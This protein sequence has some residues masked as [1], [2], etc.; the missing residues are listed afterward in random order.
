MAATILAMHI[1]MG[2]E[3]LTDEILWHCIS[4]IVDGSG[5]NR[6]NPYVVVARAQHDVLVGVSKTLPTAHCF[7]AST[8]GGVLWY[9]NMGS[10]SEAELLFGHLYQIGKVSAWL[11]GSNP[12]LSEPGEIRLLGFTMP[13][14]ADLRVKLDVWS[15]ET[16]KIRLHA[17]QHLIVY[18]EQIRKQI[19]EHE[20]RLC[21][22]A[23]MYP[24]GSAV[25]GA[26][27]RL[28]YGAKTYLITLEVRPEEDAWRLIAD[29]AG[30]DQN[31]HSWIFTY[32]NW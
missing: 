10:L 22:V 16:E 27:K 2:Q 14:N 18:L 20:K 25:V 23:L 4:R 24:P 31:M 5:P 30:N 7:G 8:D 6:P 12:N 15:A 11:I 21:C 28:E 29:C 1:A 17:Q 26:S 19:R 3:G 13:R 32:C 9:W